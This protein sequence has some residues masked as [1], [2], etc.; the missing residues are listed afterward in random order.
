MSIEL[1]FTQIE[2]ILQ[3]IR[4]PPQP[5]IMVD[6]QIEQVQPEPDLNRIAQ[7]I[8]QDVSLA[9]TMLK[10]VNSAAYGVPKSILSVQQAVMLLGIDTVIGI[11]NGL[12]IR[13]A[14]SD[15]DIVKLNRFWDTSMDVA[16]VARYIAQKTDMV[17]AD[18]AYTLG[19]FHN[20]GI[21]LMNQRFKN[22]PDVLKQAYHDPSPRLIDVEN[23]A[24]ATHHAIVGHFIAR[25]WKLP[26]AIAT[27]VAQ[28][29]NL[30]ALF[31]PGPDEADDNL[32]ALLAVL[33]IAEHLCQLHQT[34][35]HCHDAKEWQG[36]G[37]LVLEFA[38]LSDYDIAQWRDE[39]TE[40]GI[41]SVS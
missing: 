30:L 33:K 14:L 6:L 7:L 22:Y 10:I 15:E 3:G 13:D 9:G 23:E 26:D 16:Q 39:L 36:V 8:A 40:L 31:T 27:A 17:P 32:K 19:L 24:L 5:Q 28:H 37:P 41:Q 20:V 34:L 21:V 35:G 12:S 38:G 1:D 11:I 25:T 4:I 18:D 2:R 29:H